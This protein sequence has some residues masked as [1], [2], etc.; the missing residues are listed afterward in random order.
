MVEPIYC[1][2]C[3]KQ[4]RKKLLMKVDTETKGR[5]YPWCKVCHKNIEIILEPKSRTD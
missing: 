1:P 2:E 3:A 5:I 4:G